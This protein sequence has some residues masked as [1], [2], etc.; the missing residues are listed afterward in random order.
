MADP[1]TWIGSD[2]LKDSGFPEAAGNPTFV[3]GVIGTAPINEP[4]TPNFNDFAADFEASYGNAPGIFAP[5]QYDAAILLM[6]AMQRAGSTDGSAV[7][8]A[9]FEVSSPGGVLALPGRAPQ[10]L[11]I[12]QAGD[13]INYDGASGPVD[14]DENGDVLANYEVWQYDADTD[15][16]DTINVIQASAIR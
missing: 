3:D 16:F 13:D 8:D 2:G 9:L 6:F 12:L 11:L 4:D 7:R 1:V 10:T 14:F 5:H 15:A